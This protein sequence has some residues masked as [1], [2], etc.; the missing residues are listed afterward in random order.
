MPTLWLIWRCPV[1]STE[2]GLSVK[3]CETGRVSMEALAC[4]K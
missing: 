3:F 2:K 1:G 4:Q